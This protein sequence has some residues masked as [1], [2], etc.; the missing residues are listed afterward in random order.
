MS[1]LLEVR[2]V[3]ARFAVGSWPRRRWLRALHDVG[4]QLARGE[5]LALVGESGSGKSTLAR[6]VAGLVPAHAGSARLDGD[7]LLAG[8]HA[9]RA[10]RRRVQMVFQDP[11]ASINPAHPAGH[12][13]A[14]ALLLQGRATRANVADHVAQ[15]F[16][17]VGLSADLAARAPQTLSGGQR[18]RVAIARALAASP[19]LLLADEPTSM[20]DVS[21]R[22]DVLDLLAGQAHRHGRGVL[23]VTHDLASAWRVA[24]RVVVLYAGQVME[25]G[26][27]AEVLARPRH[28]YAQLLVAA[29]RRDDALDTDLPARPGRA[30]VVDPPAGCPFAARCPQVTPTCRSVD[31]PVVSLADRHVVRCHLPLS[32]GATS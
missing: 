32:S 2:G 3:G 17:A 12:G 21:L 20:L 31:P 7:D 23:L 4:F 24:D 18:Q 30:Q 16:T 14:R 1:A 9:A 5:V 25:E 6:V 11:Y 29:A 10:A 26:P 27:A 8:T 15:A 13:V 19:D 22:A 28:P